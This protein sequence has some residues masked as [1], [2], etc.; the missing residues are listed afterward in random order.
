MVQQLQ[1]STP[2]TVEVLPASYRWILSRD[3]ISAVEFNSMV[4][5][6]S[7]MLACHHMLLILSLINYAIK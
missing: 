3:L 6:L 1:L 2:L 7:Q 5:A 4:L